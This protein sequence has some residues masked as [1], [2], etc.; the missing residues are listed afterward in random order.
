MGIWGQIYFS[1][2]YSMAQRVVNTQTTQSCWPRFIPI[3]APGLTNVAGA[4]ESKPKTFVH[5]WF[6]H[7]KG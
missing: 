5:K 7:T 4:R 1:L 6:N 2:I 3:S